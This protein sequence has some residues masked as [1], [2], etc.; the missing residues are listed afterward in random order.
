[1]IQAGGKLVKEITQYLKD[2]ATLEC[3][4]YTQNHLMFS[5]SKRIEPL[6]YANKYEK[7]VWKPWKPEI[8]DF[9]MFPGLGLVGIIPGTF[10]IW[11]IMGLIQMIF[12]IR[13]YKA[14]ASLFE[15]IGAAFNIYVRIAVVL[16]VIGTICNIILGR[17]NAKD[18]YKRNVSEYELAKKS[19]ECR[20]QAELKQRKQLF[21]QWEQVA[22]EQK[23]T[24]EILDTLYAVDIIHPKYRDIVAVSSFY[25]YF[26][27]G[28]CIELTGRGGA[29]DTYEYERHLQ[30][31][32]TKLDV[33][34]S[35][36]DQIIANQ[37]LIASL[38]QEANSTL[39]RIERQNDRMMKSMS[40]M[41]ENTALTEYNTRCA[42]RSA[43]VVEHIAGYYALKYE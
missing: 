27:T 5:L 18:E 12:D 3:Q 40:R 23:R 24:K 22:K 4:L 19:D 16:S 15:T 6:G 42:A 7:P 41:E 33:I 26:D 20:V 34:I 10:I 14:T 28:R 8:M 32:E 43:A 1:M 30:I 31:I 17:K 29:Y 39:N 21:S 35:K 36:L 37:H 38:M 25:D 2:L 9:I 13:F 11:F